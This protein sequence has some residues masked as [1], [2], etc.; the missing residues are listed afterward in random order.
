MGRVLDVVWHDLS[1]TKAKGSVT[2]PS[3]SP[4]A[5]LKLLQ[6]R[7]MRKKELCPRVVYHSICVVEDMVQT[8]INQ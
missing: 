3:I 5:F 6:Q 2:Y 4:V 7:K 1:V 8:A